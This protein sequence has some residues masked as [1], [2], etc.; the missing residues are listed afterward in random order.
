MFSFSMQSSYNP[1]SSS[2]SPSTDNWAHFGGFLSGTSA[3]LIFIK[4]ILGKPRQKYEMWV[5]Y[6]GIFCLTL[7][8]GLNL[9][10]CFLKQ[11]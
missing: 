4:P 6:I 1:S 11:W 7:F 8:A 10:P 9:L 3:S 5:M 2:S